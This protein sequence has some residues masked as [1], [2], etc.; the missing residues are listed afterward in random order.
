M[1]TTVPVSGI[2][3]YSVIPQPK[4]L[5][6]VKVLLA[7]FHSKGIQSFCAWK[8]LCNV[9]QSTVP[10][11]YPKIFKSAPLAPFGLEQE[12]KPPLWTQLGMVPPGF[13]EVIPSAELRQPGSHPLQ[14]SE[15]G[16]A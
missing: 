16:A 3:L 5:L 9:S 14:R 11:D 6:A 15:L 12:Q 8:Q 10:V 7:L 1:Y 2:L 4:C 13:Q